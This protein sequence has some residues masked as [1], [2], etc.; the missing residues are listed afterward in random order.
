MSQLLVNCFKI[1]RNDTVS[2]FIALTT[3]DEIL[4]IARQYKISVYCSMTEYPF[5]LKQRDFS[6][7]A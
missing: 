2:V 4:V 3:T 7:Q 5:T 6:A 1:L